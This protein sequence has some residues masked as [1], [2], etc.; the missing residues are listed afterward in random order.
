MYLKKISLQMKK[1]YP[2]LLIQRI[3]KARLFLL[4]CLTFFCG[5]TFAQTLSI[6]ASSNKSDIL[7]GETFTYTLKYSCAAGTGD[8][9]NVTMTANIPSG[10]SFPNQVVG[11]TTDIDSYTFS[12][13]RRTATF[14][15]KNPLKAGNTGIIELVGQGDFGKVEGTTGTMTASIVSGSGAPATATVNT[16][17]HSS[18]KFCPAKANGRGLAV[19]NSTS[20]DIYLQFA[21]NYGSTGIGTASVSSVVM[22]DNLPANTVINGVTTTVLDGWPTPSIPSGTC[23]VDNTPGAPK[24]TCTFPASTFQVGSQYAPRVLVT[25]DVTY[26]SSSFSAG[27]NVTN[28]VTVSYTPDGGSAI[29]ATNG[30]TIT[31]KGGATYATQN[32]ETCTSTLSVTDKLSSPEPKLA[33]S[34]RTS[35]TK[36]RPGDVVLY[37]F[38]ASNTGNVPLTNVVL[39]DILPTDL[40]GTAVNQFAKVNMT[41]TE[42]ITYWVKT[43]VQ[44]TYYQ[45]LI[46]DYTYVP[47]SGEYITHFKTEIS[48]MPA[49]AIVQYGGIKV[50]LAPGSTA[51]SITNCLNAVSSTPGVT[52]DTQYACQNIPVAPLDNYSSL[53]V[54]KW[55]TSIPNNQYSV[56]YGV[57]QSIGTTIWSVI[58]AVNV[59]GGQPLQNPVV[60]DSTN[61]V[62]V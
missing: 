22:V 32:T 26:P 59:A 44:T 35:S 41:G 47:P 40:R 34:K 57:P 37:E 25:L 6:E 56:F 53:L 14:T 51:T 54:H 24:V 10:V 61:R 3:G 9:P 15:F 19:G 17:L 55:M 38:S 27:S 11:I 46:S 43:N 50:T 45:V 49:G 36:I 16:I 13:D 33:L 7:T 12:A 20:Y 39:E 28:N 29:V 2:Y 23:V 52:L 1:M 31:Y 62:I 4:V 58:Q 42:T 8:C 60:M 21:G 30:S 5:Q 48:S 18:N